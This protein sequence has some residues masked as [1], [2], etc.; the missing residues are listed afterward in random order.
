M[1]LTQLFDRSTA[2]V[3]LILGFAAAAGTALV[4]G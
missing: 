2:A 3:L 4:G 1:S